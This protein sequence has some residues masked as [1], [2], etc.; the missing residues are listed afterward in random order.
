MTDVQGMSKSRKRRR[1]AG[2]GT[3]VD[4]IANQLEES[5]RR[6]RERACEEVRRACEEESAAKQKRLE[7]AFQLE[8]QQLVRQHEAEL[9]CV[10]EMATRRESDSKQFAYIVRGSSLSGSVPR[11]IFEAEPD[12]VLNRLYNGEWQ[13]ALDGQGRA[14]VNSNPAHWPLIL[15]WLSFNVLPANPTPEFIAECEFWQ[16]GNLLGKLEAR[17][18]TR[19]ANLSTFSISGQ[20]SFRVSR[21]SEGGFTLK[22]HFCKFPERFRRGQPVEVAFSAFGAEWLFGLSSQGPYLSNDGNAAS[23]R[24]LT[25]VIGTSQPWQA[26]SIES[27]T[28]YDNSQ[29]GCGWGSSGLEHLLSHKRLEVNGNLPVT[30]TLL[31]PQSVAS[32]LEETSS[33]EGETSSA[34]EDPESEWE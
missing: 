22:G 32:E 15:D 3:F 18:R 8:K 34:S 1:R 24:S 9:A 13:Y 12:S 16:L 17:R 5:T 6:E 28:P 23:G 20:H 2:N 10:A 27:A 14:M 33:D 21:A 19:D 25:I 4:Q 29:W 26:C 11:Q 31:M 7:Q 30:V